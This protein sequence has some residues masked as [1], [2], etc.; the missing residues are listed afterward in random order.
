MFLKVEI[1]LKKKDR[2]GLITVTYPTSLYLQFYIFRVV[3]GLRLSQDIKGKYGP[4]RVLLFVCRA[5]QTAE[6]SLCVSV[7]LVNPPYL[8]QRQALPLLP[9]NGLLFD[10]IR[11]G[12]YV[13]R[14]LYCWTKVQSN[15]HC[16]ASGHLSQTADGQ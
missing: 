14:I 8:G 2:L 4:L 9:A 15:F 10:K 16:V 7:H 12:G 5:Y 11:S 13:P 6:E 1:A 3:N